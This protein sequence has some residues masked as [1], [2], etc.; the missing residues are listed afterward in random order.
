MLRL[1]TDGESRS[2]SCL[3]ALAM[4]HRQQSALV[5]R[6]NRLLARSQPELLDHFHAKL[7]KKSPQWVAKRYT[8]QM[9]ENDFAVLCGVMWYGQCAILGPL[10]DMLLGMPEHPLWE[11]AKVIPADAM[12]FCWGLSCSRNALRTPSRASH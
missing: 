11:L 7:I 3:S 6:S 10:F 8:R 4:L 2:G 9:L 12:L 1:R 5:V